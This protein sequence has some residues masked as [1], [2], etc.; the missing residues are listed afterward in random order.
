MADA[1][2]F[3]ALL[4]GIG[5]SALVLGGGRSR[6]DLRLR[7]R[8]DAAFDHAS[9]R[10]ARSDATGV[11]RCRSCGTSAPERAGRCPSCRAVL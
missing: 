5:V 4:A 7:R 11:L 10:I 1:V 8:W 6:E 2:W 9:R 3:I